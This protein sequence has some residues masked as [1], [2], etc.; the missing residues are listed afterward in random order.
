MSTE[1]ARIALETLKLAPR[2]LVAVAAVCGFLLICDSRIVGALGLRE[3]TDNN[4]HWLG[5]AFLTTT[6]LF[7]VNQSEEIARWV[8]NKIGSANLK[9]KRLNRLHSLTEEEKQI[10]R[11]YLAKQTR[12]NSLRIQDGIVQGLVAAG[13][14]Y[15][16]A[17]L[18]DLRSGFSYNIS[19]FVWEYLNRNPTLVEGVTNTYRTDGPEW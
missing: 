6:A 17:N 13:I 7:V 16:S 1:F 10:L 4:R 8:R 18:G 14:I 12:T 11:Y 19:D 9:K 15:Q 2:Y 3:F 5:L